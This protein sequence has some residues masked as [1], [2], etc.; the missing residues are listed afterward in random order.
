MKNLFS[1][2]LLVALLCFAFFVGAQPTNR[3]TN[4]VSIPSATASS[5]GKFGDIPV[6]NFTGTPSINIPLYTLQEGPISVPIALSYHAS[7]LKVNELASWVGL[8]WSLNAGGMISRTILNQKDEDESTG[9]LNKPLPAWNDP[10]ELQFKYDQEPDIFSY[11]F[12]GHSGKFFIDK[13]RIVHTSEK[14]DLKIE[15]KTYGNNGTNV[16]G[17][18]YFTIKTSDGLVYTFSEYESTTFDVGTEVRSGWYLTSIKEA[19]YDL[20]NNFNTFIVNFTYVDEVY[21]F[22]SR[23]TTFIQN[24]G[25][26]CDVISNCS[27]INPPPVILSSAS[28][29]PFFKGLHYNT[30]TGKRLSKISTSTCDVEF[31]TAT[32]NR[33]DLMG[34]GLNA[35]ALETICVS[36]RRGCG[37]QLQEQKQM[38]T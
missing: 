31:T 26:D 6:G 30:I 29:S 8:G 36:V 15:V 7:G 32:A 28:T 20:A 37:L 9:W 4:N 22:R 17:F 33:K 16:T 34:V 18:E 27:E 3:I 10:N 13:N 38:Q 11:N 24:S 12:N 1:C 23:P 19:S 35:K 21:S 25:L 5:L 14:S 2:C